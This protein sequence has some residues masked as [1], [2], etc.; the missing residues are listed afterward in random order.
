MFVTERAVLERIRE[1]MVITEIATGVEMERHILSQMKFQPLV[2]PHLRL[3]DARILT[4][5][6]RS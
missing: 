1:G 2:T 6:G 3:M 4:R 5:R